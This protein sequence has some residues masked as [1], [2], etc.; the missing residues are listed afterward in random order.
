MITK[1]QQYMPKNNY[2]FLD[3]KR[4]IA[5]KM[6]KQI[7]DLG[8]NPDD[9]GFSRANRDKIVSWIPCDFQQLSLRWSEFKIIPIATLLAIPLAVYTTTYWLNQY[10]YRISLGIS[11]FLAPILALLVVASV[12]MGLHTIKNILDNPVKS[13]S[14]E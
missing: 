8:I 13:L 5:N 2:Q 12:S 3:Q 14:Y 6:K 7:A 4:R 10:S 9:L 1:Q 11:I